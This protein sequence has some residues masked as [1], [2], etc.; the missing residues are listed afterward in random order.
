MIRTSSPV[1]TSRNMMTPN[2]MPSAH[3]HR[4]SGRRPTLSV[5][6]AQAMVAKMPI[7]GRDAQ[8]DK[9]FASWWPAR[10]S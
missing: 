6:C 4:Y 9:G 1:L 10:R 8:R 5:S 2:G 7:A 3:T